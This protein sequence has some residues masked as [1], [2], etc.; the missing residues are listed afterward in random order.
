MKILL[1]QIGLYKAVKQYVESGHPSQSVSAIT[2]RAL[3][4]RNPETSERGYIGGRFE[5]DVVTHTRADSEGATGEEG[6]AMDQQAA[7]EI[8]RDALRPFATAHGFAKLTSQTLPRQYAEAASA[9]A[10]TAPL[11]GRPET[12]FSIAAPTI[13]RSGSPIIK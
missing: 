3:Q 8:L 1:D 12:S 2:F 13:D 10:S 7:I 9:I 11:D 4:S 6:G 5:A